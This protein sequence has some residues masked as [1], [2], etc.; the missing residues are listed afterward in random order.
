MSHTSKRVAAFTESLIREMTRVNDQNQA[1]NLAQG[2]P[3]FDPPKEIIDAAK[4]ALDGNFNQYAI[5]WGSS[6]LRNA[7]AR[8]FLNY[9]GLEIDPARHITVCCGGTEGMIATMMAVIDSGDKVIVPLPFY[10]NYGPDIVLCGGLPIYL[11]MYQEGDGFHYRKEELINA[12]SQGVKAIVL[13]TPHNPTG[14][15][16]SFEELSFISELCQEYDAMAITDEPYEHILFDGAVHHSVA[17]LEGMSNRTIT[18]NSMSKTYSVTGWRIGWAICKDE[19]VS[20]AIRKAHDFLTVGAAAPLQ[21]A[22]VTALGLP[23]RYY[24]DLSSG[25]TERRDI[26]MSILRNNGF[27]YITPKGAYYV[28]TKYPDCGYSDGLEFSMFLSETIGV[29]P[30]PG[31]AFYP[32]ESNLG[33]PYIRFAFPKRL[34]TLQTVSEKLSKLVNYIK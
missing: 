19:D 13:N 28:M 11:N 4:S 2:F 20:S 12:F 10:E 5:T 3:D 1:V 29:T 31:S 14:K 24:A 25:Y 23:A 26:M 30:V 15:V 16:F 8:K 6:E 9:N 21:K 22:S 18:I 33:A 34:D 17:A 7:I 32:Q 27:D